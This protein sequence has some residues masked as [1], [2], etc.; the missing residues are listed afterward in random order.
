MQGFSDL[1][2]FLLATSI[3]QEIQVPHRKG[4]EAYQPETKILLGAQLAG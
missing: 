1:D 2:L 4:Y 3:G